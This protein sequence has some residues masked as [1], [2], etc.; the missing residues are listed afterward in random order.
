MAGL[1]SIRGNFLLILSLIFGDSYRYR[2]GCRIATGIRHRVGNCVYTT[3]AIARAFGA[4]F[5][6]EVVHDDDVVRRI[7]ITQS[8]VRFVRNDRVQCDGRGRIEVIADDHRSCHI[9]I[10]VVGRPQAIGGNREFIKHWGNFVTDIQA[11]DNRV[12]IGGAIGILCINGIL[13]GSSNEVS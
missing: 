11:D 1:F 2:L 9:H 7:A 5:E 10:L 13:G 12:M 8:I 3:I 4:E 6:V